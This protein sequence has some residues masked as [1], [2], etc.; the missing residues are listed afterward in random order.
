MFRVLTKFLPS[1]IT[2]FWITVLRVKLD[3]LMFN[4]DLRSVE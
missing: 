1:F 2:E 4:Q 3:R